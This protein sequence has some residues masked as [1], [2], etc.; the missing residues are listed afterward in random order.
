MKYILLF[1]F[2]INANAGTFSAGNSY[3]ISQLKF[4]NS[5]SVYTDM[6]VYPDKILKQ[7]GLIYTTAT[8]GSSKGI[9]FLVSYNENEEPLLMIYDWS[10]KQPIESICQ[11]NRFTKVIPLYTLN[12]DCYYPKKIWMD[13]NYYNTMRYKN[14]TKRIGKDSWENTIHIA[15]YCTG[16]YELYYSHKFTEKRKNVLAND[17]FG[18]WGP[19]IETFFNKDK[20]PKLPTMGFRNMK[21]VIDNNTIPFTDSY[22][23]FDVISPYVYGKVTRNGWIIKNDVDKPCKTCIIDIHNGYIGVKND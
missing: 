15:N 12:E 7:N 5:I 21:F 22:V 23:G 13:N 18:W 2:V 3:N 9:E 4:Q 16:K 8:N 17:S 10:C 14:T 11:I 1:L 20:L 19:F 6:I